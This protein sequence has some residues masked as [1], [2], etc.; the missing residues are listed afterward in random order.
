LDTVWSATIFRTVREPQLASG[1]SHRGI[2]RGALC[3]LRSRAFIRVLCRT[4]RAVALHGRGG[5]FD[6]YGIELRLNQTITDIDRALQVV[7]DAQGHETRWDKLVLATGSYPFVPPVPGHDARG[8]FVYRTL[9][10]LDEIAAR[11]KNAT[12]GVVI[13]GGLL[14]L[15][16]ANALKQLGLETHVVE[17]AP[18]LMAVQ[19]DEQ[20]GAMLRKKITALGV[21]V[22]T[23]KATREIV[24]NGDTLTLNFADGESLTTDM[25]VFSAGIRPQDALARSGALDLGN[26]A[27]SPLMNS[28][29]PRMKTSS[30]S[31]NVRCGRAKSMV[32]WRQDIRWRV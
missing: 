16:A 8:C 4:Q 15:E 12:R 25:V 11:A 29:R 31:A 18:A 2:R 7:R 28:A 26:A 21:Q 30:P 9:D 13:G 6:Q 14:G 27:G 5:F 3:R 23:S 10:D 17:F 22:H 19:L 32:W 20:G 1:L 24:A